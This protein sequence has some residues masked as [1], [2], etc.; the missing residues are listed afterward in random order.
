MNRFFRCFCINQFGM[1][2]FQY[3]SSRFNFGF[4][5][6]EIFVFD[7]QLPS[8][9]DKGNHRLCV[10]VIQRVADSLYQ[11]YAE[12]LTPRIVDTGSRLLNFLKENSLNWWYGESTTPRISESGSQ[13]LRVSV[14]RGVNKSAYQWYGESPTLRIGDSGSRY[15]NT[16][17]K[18]PRITDTRIH[19]LP[20]SLIRRVVNSPHQW[21]RESL[22]PHIVDRGVAI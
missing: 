22:T 9:N 1:G 16:F 7:K 2:P 12:S 6:A 19:R 4:K 5:F 15:L 21:Y 10:S 3:Y 20:T 17:W 14:I 18:T 8:I 11:W 13:R